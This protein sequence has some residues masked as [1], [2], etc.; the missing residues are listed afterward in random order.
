MDA[1]GF[2]PL[3]INGGIDLIAKYK[4]V[5]LYECK[6]HETRYGYAKDEVGQQLKKFGYVK[7]ADAGNKNAIIGVIN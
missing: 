1:E 7:I 4:P 6:G 3:I 2:E 5:I